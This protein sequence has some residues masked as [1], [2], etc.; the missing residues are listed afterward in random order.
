MSAGEYVVVQVFTKYDGAEEGRWLDY[1]RTYPF[2]AMQFLA[3][4][5]GY[6]A[7]HWIRKEVVLSTRQLKVM[8]EMV[9]PQWME[10]PPTDGD[11]WTVD[12]EWATAGGEARYQE[13]FVDGWTGP[14]WQDLVNDLAREAAE[15]GD[16]VESLKLR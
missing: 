12:V 8:A 13:R 4:H 15:T 7:V 5:T 9:P 16:R 2:E 10:R 1:C 3:Q 11:H 14:G 6:R